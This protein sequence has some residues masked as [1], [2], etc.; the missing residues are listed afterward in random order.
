M[1]KAVIYQILN[2]A[3]GKIYIGSSSNY[4][5]RK[6]GHLTLLRKNKHHS[7]KLQ[8]SYNRHGEDKFVFSLL[9]SF[10]YTNKEEIL[11]RE[12]EYITSLKPYYN[13]CSIAGSCLGVKRTTK[14]RKDLS[15]RI[16]VRREKII[17][18]I[19][20]G[21]TT[22][23]IV[24]I[25]KIS[26]SAIADARKELKDSEGISYKYLK[27]RVIDNESGEIFTTIRDAAKSKSI[28]EITLRKYLNNL[29]PN[30]TKFTYYEEKI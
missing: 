10:E 17:S 23:E 24:E 18:Y 6:I 20:E 12:Q 16:R 25:M 21:K 11:K 14:F 15:A 8:N 19:K 30:K 2:L 28:S 5:R 22:G 4:S 3:T 13:I 29:I 7:R 9:E 1:K 27:K 26:R